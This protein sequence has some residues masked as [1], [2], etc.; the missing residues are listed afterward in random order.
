[1]YTYLKVYSY[2]KVKEVL[3]CIIQT[4]I[5]QQRNLRNYMALINAHCIIMMILVLFSP[6]HKGDNQYRYYTESQSIELQFIINVE[7]FTYE[8]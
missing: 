2:C 8:S 4:P 6:K 7:R 3:S 5:I 1:M